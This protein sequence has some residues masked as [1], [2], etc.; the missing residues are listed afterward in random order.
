MPALVKDV[1]P[2]TKERV[3]GRRGYR[4]ALGSLRR[5]PSPGRAPLATKGANI[6]AD[7]ATEH[8]PPT[9]E[10]ASWAW[11]TGQVTTISTFHAR[12]ATEFRSFP[13][14]GG[15]TNLANILDADGP[16]VDLNLSASPEGMVRQVLANDVMSGK[17]A[18]VVIAL[19][20]AEQ[21]SKA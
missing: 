16:P 14:R 6:I 18:S 4:L 3:T 13:S 12:A 19:P 1:G 9:R 2:V 5:R 7:L 17:R 10:K 8:A 11:V 21:A 20:A 15:A